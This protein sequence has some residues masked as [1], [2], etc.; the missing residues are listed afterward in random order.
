MKE[1]IQAIRGM[2]DVLPTETPYWQRIESVCRDVVA[3]YGYHEIRFPILEQTKLFKRSVGEATDIVE[4]E[5]YTFDDRNG[6]SLSMR[7]E[8]T[9]GCVRAG[10][11]H[12][13][14]Y[15]QIQRMWYMGP[16]FR[17]ERPQ[18]GRLR[19]FH[20][21]G[22]EAFGMLNPAIDVEMIL[23]SKRILE[24][25]GLLNQITLQINNLGDFNQRKRYQEKLVDYFTAHKDQLDED[26]LRR[27]D[28]NPLRILDSK[29][30]EMKSVIEN[31]PTLID[32]IQTDVNFAARN[33][34][35]AV[36]DALKKAGIQFEVNP[37][38]VRGLDYYCLTVFEWVTNNLGAQGTVCAGGRYDGLVEQLGGKTTSAVGFAMGVERIALLLAEKE[39]IN[40]APD[41]YVI[42]DRN[43]HAF[44]LIENL[45]NQFPAL[46]IEMDLV[47]TGAP[48]K[49]ADKSG[50]K[51]A[52]A[53]NENNR[54]TVKY[55]RENA[56]Q[57]TMTVDELTDFFE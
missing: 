42:S 47:E 52:L 29:N 57:K 3:Q 51:Y 35:A 15:N 8:G 37:H 10:I 4:K 34:F 24:Q 22:V 39:K 23:L 20:Q 31:A 40:D 38:L 17:H 41:C 21:L 50:A 16:M 53:I 26:A 46:K 11:E 48:M 33:H 25:L 30:P 49:R 2:N 28:K 13:L 43:A 56:E 18:K 36:C 14:L 5:M 1:K 55:L 19:Q 44:S 9:A 32:F 7:P 45:R 54:V 12:G 27:L 6:D